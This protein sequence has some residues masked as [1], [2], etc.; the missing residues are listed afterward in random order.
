MS[1][2]TRHASAE[3]IA[4]DHGPMCR[5]TYKRTDGSVTFCRLK[6]GHAGQHWTDWA[7]EPFWWADAD[8]EQPAALVVPSTPP[9]KGPMPHNYFGLSE[10]IIVVPCSGNE[11]VDVPV[12]P[13]QGREKVIA[14]LLQYVQHKRTC[15]LQPY[16][17]CTCGL[18]TLV[19]RLRKGE[20]Q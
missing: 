14:E 20:T 12:T 6:P 9:E 18:S 7:R 19:A 11:P 10:N 8:S 2:D 13:D 1:G 16:G 15:P 17:D 4:G 3:E 5:G